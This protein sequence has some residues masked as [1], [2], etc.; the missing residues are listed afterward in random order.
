MKISSLHE[1]GFG[2]SSEDSHYVQKPRGDLY[3]QLLINSSKSYMATQTSAGLM[4]QLCI[5]TIY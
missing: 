4:L 1:L 3:F 2:S 5:G